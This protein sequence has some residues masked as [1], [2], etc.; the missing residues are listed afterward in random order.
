MTDGNRMDNLLNKMNELVGQS[1]NEMATVCG[2]EDGFGIIIQIHSADHPPAHAHVLDTSKNPLGKLLL[3]ESSP[4]SD[5]DIKEYQPDKYGYF[6]ADTKKTILRWSK[7][8]GKYSINN[9]RR[10]LT[11]WD[12]AHVQE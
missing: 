7:A 10:S 3:T 12:S 9:W 1:L 11:V 4:Q 6:D 8:N 2:K 5:A